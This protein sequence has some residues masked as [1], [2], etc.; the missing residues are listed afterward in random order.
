MDC[1][2]KE[3]NFYSVFITRFQSENR[4]EGS[5][6]TRKMLLVA[7]GMVALCISIKATPQT[8]EHF[9]FEVASVKPNKPEPNKPQVEVMQGMSL[10]YLPGGRL[11]VQGVPI[12]V[13]I[14]EAYS[15]APGPSRRISLSPAFQKS[16]DHAMESETYN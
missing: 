11:S 8:A 7:V 3:V 9:S 12:P 6:K 5:M 16:M 13:L 10:R 2:M 4:I 15:V 1:G 14:F